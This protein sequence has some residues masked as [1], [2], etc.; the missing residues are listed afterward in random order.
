MERKDLLLVIRFR[1]RI[2][3][4]FP[5]FLGTTETA[6]WDTVGDLLASLVQ[7]PAAFHETREMT[8]ADKGMNPLHFGAIR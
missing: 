4:H 5:T 8:N 6:E 3:D 1:V 2:L 7:S